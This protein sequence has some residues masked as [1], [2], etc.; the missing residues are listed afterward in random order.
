MSAEVPFVILK[1]GDK[2]KIND[3]VYCSPAWSA[4]DGTPYSVARIMEFLPPEGTLKGKAQS[5][6]NY[7]RVR[8]AW[9]Y[10][11]SDVSDRPVADCRLLLAAIYSEVC[12][13][14]Q[15]RSKCF[16]IHRNK[17]SDLAGW[18]KRPDR[19]YFTRLFDPYIKKEF[20]VILS[21]DVRNLP[22]H[23]REVLISRYEYVVAEKEI[24]PDLT[25]SLRLCATCE[26]W[27]PHPE[28]VQCDRCKKFFHMSCVQPPLLAKPSRGYGWTCAP[29]SRKHEEEVDS[30][31]VVRHITPSQPSKP[32][33]NA[34]PARGR[35]RPRKDRAQA[36]KEENMEIKH[37]QMWPF[38]YFGLYTVAED[39]LDPED[40]IFPRTATRVGAKFQAVVPPLIDRD[41]PNA[42]TSG[43]DLE[44]RGGDSTIEVLSIVNEMKE[45]E[46][47][48]MERCKRALTSRSDLQSSVDWLTEVTRR[49]CEAYLSHRSF[50]TV[51]MK[52]P[53]RFEKWK[54]TETRYTDREWNDEEMA[55]FEEGIHTYGPE[56][57]SVRDEVRTR[58][59]A[60]V[61]RYY[62]HWKNAKLRE[63]NAR[64]R[65]GLPAQPE[66]HHAAA[67]ASSDDE[68][69]VIAQPSK[70]AYCGA[71]RTRD[72]STWWKAPKG[73]ATSSML[74]DDCGL[75]WRK[76]ADLHVRP[77]RDGSAP[78][79]KIKPPLAERI[80]K[81]EGTPLNGPTAKRAKVSAFS[82][83]P[84]PAPPPAAPQLRCLGCQKSG[85][86]GKVLKCKECQFRV[87]AGSCGALVD[88]AAVESWVCDLCHN[89]K[90]L[91]A[92]L[93]TDCLLCPRPKR[94]R[95]SKAP[96][97]PPDTYLR[98]CKPT[99]GQ[100]WVHVLCSVFVPETIY[101][102]ASR[103]RLVEGISTIPLHRWSTKCGL[104]E[105]SGGAVVRCADCPKEFH[106]S[107]AWQ[108]G[109]KFGFEIQPVKSTRRELMTV[110]NFREETGSMNPIISCK[111][112]ANTSKRIIYE[113]CDMND[114]GE[115]ALQVYCS[116]YKQVQVA[117]SHG[118]LRK[119]KRLDS[120]LN[121]RP[122]EGHVAAKSGPEPHCF[123]CGTEFAP[124][125]YPFRSDFVCHRCYFQ[126]RGADDKPCTVS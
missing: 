94:D 10:R 74:C 18:K 72:S 35:G 39:T 116:N 113:I 93:N 110:V 41:N 66:G 64:I 97:P 31:E 87:H 112:H 88:P 54:K 34:P 71:C 120:I 106:I 16:V 96:Y 82:T 51:N 81:R 57:R 21:T 55:A 98:A 50:S 85:P 86:L 119:A 68:G 108:N 70:N 19:F 126:E 62:G 30:H 11:P 125:F 56:L 22:S 109:Y 47:A 32:K 4:R 121:I 90:A 100:G 61:V 80:E 63:E 12:D 111:E 89:Q 95:K 79:A 37:Y 92:S 1:N 69:S 60:E 44:E 3:H 8:L 38:R 107:C 73:L 40:L 45:E 23:I 29:C 25:D 115:T 15:L 67:G 17:I 24:V 20:E 13:I 102:D 49:M 91:E 5:N 46:V 36:E 78:P 84:P 104:C 117:Q 122:T 105:Q 9:Y 75:N 101:S 43:P 52:S 42:S 99:E 26:E 58:T 77:L 27:C 33:S 83:P 124:L 114:S 65:A 59:I 7:A 76:Y 103:L 6:E 48:E 53:M 14:S 2:V 118:L 28:T 123:K